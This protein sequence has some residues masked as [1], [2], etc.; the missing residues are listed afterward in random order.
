[1][2]NQDQVIEIV[3]IKR[4]SHSLQNDEMV[5]INKYA[6]LMEEFLTESAN[7]E[8]KELFPKFH[9]TLV[10]DKLGLTGVHKS[11][12]EG[13]EAKKILEHINWRTFL[14]R[15]RK[16]HEGFLKEAERQKKIAVKD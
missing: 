9:I 10:C 2:S 7:K 11:A 12:F 3:E 8:F 1:M 15:T 14:L 13:L 16:M 5:R 6:E 4:P